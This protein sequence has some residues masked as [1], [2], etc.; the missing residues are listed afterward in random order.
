MYKTWGQGGGGT[1]SL[2]DIEQ[3]VGI[4]SGSWTLSLKSCQ[5]TRRG[6]RVE[7][8]IHLTFSVKYFAS[9][10]QFPSVCM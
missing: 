6:R 9:D 3:G 5:L 1:R 10:R 7:N 8:H 2:L 4:K